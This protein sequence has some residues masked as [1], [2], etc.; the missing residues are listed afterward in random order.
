MKYRI[1]GFDQIKSFYTTVFENQGKFKPN[2]VSL[3]VFLINQNNRN[4]WVEWFKCPYDLAMAGACINSKKTYYS[5]LNDLQDWGLIKYE[6]GVNNW[7]APMIKIEV[8]KCT[9]TVPQ[10][11][12][13]QEQA[14]EPL[15]EPLDTTLPTH[16]YKLITNNLKPITDNYAK[17][18][19]FVRDLSKDEKSDKKIPPN[20]EDVKSYCKE[21]K[22]DVDP[23]RWFD[24]YSAKNWMI[25]KNK[26]KDWKAAVRTWEKS[27]SNG[28]SNGKISG[29]RK[30][31]EEDYTKKDYS[32]GFYD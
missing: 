30:Q 2:H 3:Y 10:S 14:A 8:Q 20:I 27:E 31:L 19:K 4:N 26:M 16:I 7:K 23:E 5:C 24:F 28:R 11:E 25:G 6:K 21:R 12:P 9:S 1:N 13:L 17:F 18:E 15:P 32:R 22:N 29:K